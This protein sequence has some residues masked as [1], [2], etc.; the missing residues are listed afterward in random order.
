LLSRFIWTLRTVDLTPYVGNIVHLRFRVS[1]VGK[2]SGPDRNRAFGYWLDELAIADMQPTPTSTEGVI[3]PPTETP[4][5]AHRRTAQEVVPN[6]TPTA[7]RQRPAYLGN[8]D[9]DGRS[10]RCERQSVDIA[11][12]W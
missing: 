8:R 10:A 2:L 3:V 6:A 1:T 11:A 4:T 5:S 7:S 9:A 12:R